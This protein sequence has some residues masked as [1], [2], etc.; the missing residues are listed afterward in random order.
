M[1]RA[2]RASAVFLL[3]F[4]GCE[5]SDQPP[6][7]IAGAGRPAAIAA[8]EASA[9]SEA[10]G[11]LAAQSAVAAGADKEILFGDLHVHTTYSVDAF[12]FG[13]PLFGGE[14]V[15]PPADACDYARYCSQLDFFSLNDHAEGLTPLRWQQ[16]IESVRECN[17]RAGD[18]ADPDL[19]AYVGWRT[20]ERDLPGPGQRRAACAPD[21][22]AGRRCDEARAL[23]VARARR[24]SGALGRCAAL[25]RL[26]VVDPP[27]RVGAALRAGCRRTR[28]AARLH[29]GRRGS[30]GV[31]RE[32]RAMAASVARDP[33]RSRLG[34]PR[35]AGLDARAPAD[36]RAPR[37]GPPAAARG[38]L[39]PRRE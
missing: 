20:Q 30:G 2:V 36:A 39:R 10:R 8:A 1:S 18:P 17:A 4:A 22:C 3:C 29:G 13:L 11:A 38:V 12:L 33:A 14:G 35:A 26:P 15:H 34:H 27:A 5:G 24:R 7:E 31:V 16:S 21:L 32:A 9:Q 23:P 28:P 37:P 6:G 19:V 25:R